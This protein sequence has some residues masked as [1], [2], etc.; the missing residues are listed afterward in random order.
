MEQVKIPKTIDDPIKLLIWDIRDIVPAVICLMVGILANQLGMF[1]LIG[2]AIGYASRKFREG[3]Q[4]GW[5]LQ[6]LYWIG[7]YP[8][9]VLPNPFIRR[10]LP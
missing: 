4:E 1:L 8:S 5:A 10:Y 9:T 6:A 2:L 3:R 7:L